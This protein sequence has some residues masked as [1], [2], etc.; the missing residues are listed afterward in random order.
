M[1]GALRKRTSG[2]LPGGEARM[3]SVT[4]EALQNALEDLVG[5]TCILQ[6]VLDG[7]TLPTSAADVLAPGSSGL[8]YSQLNELLLLLGFDRVTHAF[9]Q[10]LIDGTTQYRNFGPWRPRSETSARSGP[11]RRP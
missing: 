3:S 2:R 8:G 11:S 9:F 10:F 4:P 7:R 6:S 1:A 5:Q